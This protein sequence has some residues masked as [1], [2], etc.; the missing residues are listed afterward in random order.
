MPLEA[1]VLLDQVAALLEE[2]FPA[3]RWITGEIAAATRSKKGH[4]HLQLLDGPVVLTVVVL[5]PHATLV[6]QAF[7]HAGLQLA[8]GLTVHALGTPRLYP[9]RAQVELHA[10]DLRPAGLG[11]HQRARE[12]ARDLLARE[13]LLDAQRRRGL[14]RPPRT[15]GIVAPDGAGLADLLTLLA[16]SPARYQVQVVRHPGEGPTAPERIAAAI[17]LAARTADL[18]VLAR[19]GGAAITRPYDTLTV[20]RAVATCPV[21]II[22]ALG[23]A[24]DQSLTDQVAWRAVPTPSAAAALLD[25]GVSFTDGP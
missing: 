10:T 20:A 12:A 13:G 7:R 5:E 1:S 19:G 17:S 23:H 24:T 11:R 14:P 22:T 6:H 4:W 2:R 15:I 9:A 3:P 16:R 21:P 25:H 8:P 18:I